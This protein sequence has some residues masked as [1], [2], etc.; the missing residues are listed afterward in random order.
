MT[1]KIIENFKFAIHFSNKII[2]NVQ[3]NSILK[4]I[5]LNA[6]HSLQ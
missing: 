3:K 5:S 2:Q 1:V 4:H 6:G